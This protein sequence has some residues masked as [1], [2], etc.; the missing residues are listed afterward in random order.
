M[1]KR[2][3]FLL[4]T[5]LLAAGMMFA[6]C[7]GNSAPASSGGS[8]GSGDGTP[9]A[10]GPEIVLKVNNFIPESSPLAQG[11]LKAAEKLRELSG[12]TMDAEVYL[13]GTL[14]GFN[15][16]WQ[17]TGEGAVDIGYLGPAAID[18]NTVLNNIFSTPIPDLPGINLKASA[19]YN[20]LIASQPSLNEE[21]AK[22]N[23][24]WLAVEAL[25]GASLHTTKSLVKLPSESKGLVIEGMGAVSSK[26]WEALGC[27]TVTLDPG[28]YFVSLER[29]VINAYYGQW[30]SLN[31]YKTVELLPYHT[32]FGDTSESPAGSGLSTGVMGYVINLDTW[33]KLTEEQQG[34]LTQA[35]IEGGIFANTADLED[36]KSGEKYAIDNGQEI[37]HVDTP[38]LLQPWYDSMGTVV[39][40]W[41]ADA[42][43]AGYDGK[44]VRE[45]LLEILRKY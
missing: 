10:E 40:A 18:A 4:L 21:L 42:E 17:G 7:G 15:D 41:Y 27:T 6:G 39:D 23:L 34:W 44:A 25:P 26:Y 43:A 36:I 32:I 33:N 37:Y 5:V 8:S 2:M 24:R 22:S 16:T 35:F 19:A 28:D 11:S 45:A 30:A 12:G 1:K 20:E 38:E 3:V 14:L 13:N 29:G 31:N 9:A